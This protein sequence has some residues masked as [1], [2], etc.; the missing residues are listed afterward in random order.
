MPNLCIII[1]LNIHIWP[2]VLSLSLFT[3]ERALCFRQAGSLFVCYANC[4]TF[5]M[6]ITDCQIGKHL[7]YKFVMQITDC[8]TCVLQ[9][10]M[11]NCQAFEKQLTNCE[12]KQPCNTG[13]PSIGCFC[14]YDLSCKLHCNCWFLLNL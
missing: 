10:Q 1:I 5:V 3:L 8:Q 14:Q 6:Q 4:Q 9:M 13:I 11:K 2:I 12:E 7:S